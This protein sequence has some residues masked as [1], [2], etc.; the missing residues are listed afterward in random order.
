MS[1][2]V[3]STVS[4]AL[5]LEQGYH[6]EGFFMLLP[7]PGLEQQKEKVAR[8]ADKLRIPLHFIDLREAFSRQV[9]GYFL[10]SYQQGI[11][12][13]PCIFCNQHIKFGLLLDVMHQKGMDK[14][15]S[16]HYAGIISTST[17]HIIK[18]GADPRKDQSYFLCRLTSDQLQH[19]LF[20]LNELTKDTTFNKA[21]TLGFQFNGEESQDVCFLQSDLPSFLSTHG[22]EEQPGDIVTLEGQKLGTHKGVW[23]YTIGQRRGLGLP[24]AT[25]WYVVALDGAR[26]Q[27]IAGKQDDLLHTELTVHSLIWHCRPASFPWQGG[28]QIRSR[29]TAVQAEVIPLEHDRAK[30]IFTTP[31]RAVTPGQYAAFY[32]GDKLAGSGI[33][34]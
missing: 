15:A 22:I 19:H 5:L 1:G 11:T 32:V 3:D 18:R 12:P 21:E 30:V 2:G 25:P 14:T 10:S 33:I 23:R 16:G 24:D 29:H 20:P 17:S 9:L 6:V 27:V 28:V 26:N 8:V 4:A 7:V 31:Q 34:E 13:N